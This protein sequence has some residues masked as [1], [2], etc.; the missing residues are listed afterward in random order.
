[1][2]PYSISYILRPQSS[3]YT[4]KICIVSWTNLSILRTHSRDLLMG[5]KDNNTQAASGSFPGRQLS[6]LLSLRYLPGQSTGFKFKLLFSGDM[7]SLYWLNAYIFCNH[8]VPGQIL[9]ALRGLCSSLLLPAKGL[10]IRPLKTLLPPVAS[11]SLSLSLSQPP[12]WVYIDAL[13]RPTFYQCLP[14]GPEPFLAFFDA[15][16]TSGESVAFHP[17]ECFMRQSPGD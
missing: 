15:Q 4:H 13:V 11:L 7:I 3:T 6:L 16:N 5:M 9:E 17:R 10:I 14:A 12:F 2:S 1:M 8:L